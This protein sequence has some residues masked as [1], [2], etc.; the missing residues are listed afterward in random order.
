MAFY[1]A[2]EGI[3]ICLRT[4]IPSLFPFFFLSG[5]INSALIGVNSHFLRP[6]SRLCRIPVG[7][8]SL[9]ILGLTGGYPVGANATYT[10]YVS[11][12]MSR[13]S[14]QRMIAFCNNAGPAFVFGILSPLFENRL[15]CWT[16]WGIHI[17]TAILVAVLLPGAETETCIETKNNSANVTQFLQ[18][19]IR[20][21]ATVCGWVI[22]FRIVMGFLDR[23]FLWLLPKEIQILL[24]GLLELSNGC[25]SLSGIVSDGLRFV[26][27]TVFL[28][29]GGVCVAMQTASV[30]GDLST[31]SYL[32]GKGMQTAL[33]LLFAGIMQNFLFPAGTVHLPFFLYMPGIF[34][35]SLPILKKT[36]AF[37]AKI[38]Y[39]KENS[40]E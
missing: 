6:L 18:M 38:R 10:A 34:V 3:D 5:I 15:A 19:A 11:G 27:A 16:L 37:P 28:A 33:S 23:W 36:V 26:L 4:I 8:E 14:A 1:A 35:L 40:P 25:I 13:R 20:N 30:I 29:F 12:S 17:C 21:T 24:C 32:L 2:N 31:K 39:N 22:L 9:M 7:A